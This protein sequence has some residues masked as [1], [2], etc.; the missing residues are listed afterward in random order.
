MFTDSTGKLKP[1]WATV[2]SL[3]LCGLAFFVSGN[4][5][6]EVT[7]Q[8][9]F[10]VEFAF[11]PL[12]MLLLLGIFFWLLTVADHIDHQRLAAMGLPRTKGFVKHFLV[13]CIIGFL[14]TSLAVAPIHFWGHFRS[15]D[16]FTVRLIPNI[17][18]VVLTLLCGALAEELMFRGYPFQHLVQGIGAVRAVVVFSILYGLLHLQNPAPGRWGIADTILIGV[19]LSVACLR[20]QALWLPW[21]IHFGWNLTL[22]VLFGLPVS[23]Y[24]FY[25]VI[26][27]TDAKGPLWVT[28]GR[29]GVEASATGAVVI[30]LG[31]LLVWK[32]PLGKLPQ[33]ASAATPEPAL[34]DTLSGIK[35]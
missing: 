2:F 1:V 11:R 30:L 8:H 20:T 21:G 10:R 5:A 34:R 33:P 28:G 29:Y 32:L 17:G 18:A 4:I 27:Y 15:T 9:P 16:L 19:L 13:G 23:G 6:H 26:R 7:E 25:N 22:G 3:I 12:W 14:L 35:P 31:I 24:R